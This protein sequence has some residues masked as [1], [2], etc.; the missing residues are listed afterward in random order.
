MEKYDVLTAGAGCAGICAAIQAARVLGAGR[1]CLVEKNGVCGGTTTVGGINFPGIFHAWGRQVIGGI[2][3]ELVAQTRR[4]SGWPLPAHLLEYPTKRPHPEFHIRIDA[5]VFAALAE[6]WM[7]AA[8]VVVKYHTMVGAVHDG[9]EGRRVTLCGKDG[10][11]DVGAKVLVDCTG[12]A[13]LAK[14]AGSELNVAEVC[15]PGTFS[16]HAVGYDFDKLDLE[17]IRR[18]FEAAAARGEVQVD[19]CGWGAFGTAFLRNHGNNANHVNGINACDSEGRTRMEM[20][21]RASLMRLFRFLKTQKGFEH[22]E[23]KP[24]ASECGV[25]ETRTIRGLQTVTVDDYVS[26]RVFDNAVCYSYYP[27]DLHDTKLRLVNR[28]VQEG[29]VPTVP[30]GALI[31]AGLGDFL[32]AGRIVS[33]DR[34]ANSALRVQATCMATGQ[35]AGAAAALA[36]QSGR[37]PAEV[38]MDELRRVLRDNRAILPPKAEQVV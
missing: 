23:F 27:I 7:A 21:G 20:A 34:L 32:A 12:D 17:E 38:G 25:R 35:A 6:E 22:L 4:E 2:G 8:G 31:P 1:V 33:S 5:T 13:N 3:W 26:G 18:N 11:Y 15:Q 16:C 36:V 14:I 37:Q 30:L 9:A 28:T 24:V 29:C 10:L 19:D